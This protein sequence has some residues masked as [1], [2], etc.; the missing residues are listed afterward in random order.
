M[1]TLIFK[2]TKELQREKEN[3]EKALEVKI[4]VQGKT[5][6]YMAD[7]LPSVGHIPL[8]YVMGY[9]MQPLVT[10]TE[11]ELFLQEAITNNYTL[12]FEHDPMHECCNLQVTEKGIRAE[13]T[14]LLSNW[15]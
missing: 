5:L 1:E 9:D 7:L 6:V 14:F 13:N 11:K 4:N 8:P 3:L 10:L 2:R 15:I 12:F